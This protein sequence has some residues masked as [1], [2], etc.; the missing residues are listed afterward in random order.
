[1]VILGLVIE[2][3][4]MTVSVIAQGLA[5]RFDYARFSPSTVYNTLPRQADSGLVRRTHK[6]LPDQNSA[7]DRYEITKQGAQEFY[8]WI[9]ATT[10]APPALRESLY[11]RIELCEPKDIPFLVE[12]LRREETL[13]KQ[14]LSICRGRLA[15]YEHDEVDPDHW[16]AEW[17]AMLMTDQGLVWA[18]RVRRL[19]RLRKGLEDIDAKYK[20]ATDGG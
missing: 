20:G 19:Q 5:E 3:P 11:G 13:C 8:D 15:S 10:L 1:M 2:R 6:A 9:H 18:N 12:M 7:A 16:K 17:P 14:A 4:D